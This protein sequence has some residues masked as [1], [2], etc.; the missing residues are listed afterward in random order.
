VASMF[1]STRERE[2]LALK[3]WLVLVLFCLPAGVVP[4]AADE[5]PDPGGSL[6]G[7]GSEPKWEFSIAPYLWASSLEG[8]VTAGGVTTDIDMPFS[9]VLSALD[10]GLMG[11]VEARRGRFIILVDGFWAAL[12]D[13]VETRPVNVGI[14]PLTLNRSLVVSKGP[15]T[16]TPNLQVVIPRVETQVGPIEVD[17][18]ITEVII[19]AKLGWRAFDTGMS[20]LFGHEPVENDPRRFVVD[21]LGGVRYWYL[22]TELDVFIPPVEIPGFRIQTS[23]N[24]PRL[25]RTF[26][27]GDIKVPGRVAF[28]GLDQTFRSTVDWV[29][30]IVGARVIA[31]LTPK[32]SLMVIGDLGGFG[33][34]SSSSFTWNS[35]AILGW[36]LSEHWTAVAGYRALYINRDSGDLTTKGPILGAI[37][38]F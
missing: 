14:G 29:D 23:V 21:L 33:I 38:R 4:A 19:D 11:V 31:D 1:G 36:R 5:P 3:A 34:G 6:A 7:T 27:T 10:I 25:G 18:D 24:L 12:S 35:R 37:Y 15:L 32:L 20:G 2:G 17:A 16:L 13:E 30:F 22:K 28:G 26:Q 9:D 8:E